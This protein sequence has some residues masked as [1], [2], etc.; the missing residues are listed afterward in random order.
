MQVSWNI[1]YGDILPS[2]IVNRVFRPALLTVEHGDHTTG[3][4]DHPFIAALEAATIILRRNETDDI[5]TGQCRS[6]AT[7]PCWR[8]CT[9]KAL[10]G[11]CSNQMNRRA[12]V[13]ETKDDL[14]SP[15]VN[16]SGHTGDES[17]ETVCDSSADFPFK[18]GY[19]FNLAFMPTLTIYSNIL[20]IRRPTAEKMEMA[21]YHQK[22]FVCTRMFFSLPL[23]RLCGISS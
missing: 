1:D 16:T 9:F 4:V 22:P 21:V 18:R 17:L 23:R 11:A 6:I 19:D 8:P 5:G 20:T 12:I 15:D 7:L 2:C 10:I 13:P 3:V 14:C